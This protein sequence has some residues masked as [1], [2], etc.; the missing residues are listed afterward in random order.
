M[1]TTPSRTGPKHDLGINAVLPGAGSMSWEEFRHL[2]GR[3]KDRMMVLR[4]IAA[5]TGYNPLPH[6][7]RAHR[8]G[9]RHKLL[10]GGVGSGKDLFQRRRDGDPHDHESR[11]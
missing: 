2:A 6:Q 10:L 8:A 9:A 7:L 4:L 1:T 5:A 11:M 3:T